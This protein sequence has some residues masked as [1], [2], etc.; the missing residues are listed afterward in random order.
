MGQR[1]RT[2]LQGR[3][4]ETRRKNGVL[5]PLRA[6]V[7]GVDCSEKRRGKVMDL[8]DDRSVRLACEDEREMKGFVVATVHHR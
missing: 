8:N 7:S 5:C 3:E 1:A 2:T 4:G 6:Y